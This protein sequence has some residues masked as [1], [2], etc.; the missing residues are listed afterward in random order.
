MVPSK[1]SLNTTV[2][3]SM[4]AAPLANPAREALCR[5]PYTEGNE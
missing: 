2:V 3:M 4:V 1:S 5:P